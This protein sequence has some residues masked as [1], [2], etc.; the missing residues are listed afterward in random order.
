MKNKLFNYLTLF[1][2]SVVVLSAC[3]KDEPS[4]DLSGTV[5]NSTETAVSN[6]VIKLYS[7]D[8]EVSSTTS[9]SDGRYNFSGIK[10]GTYSIK[11]TKQGYVES[12]ED[13][14]IDGETSK[15]ITILGNA[16]VSGRIINSQTGEGLENATVSFA[17]N[18]NKS[19]DDMI[20]EIQVV[21]DAS[22][23]YSFENG[24]TGNFTCTI[25]ADGF[26]TRVIVNVII[27]AGNNS[28]E[29][30]TIVEVIEEGELRVVLTW[31]Q[32]PSDLDSH[33]TGPLASGE[34]FHI[35]YSH[36]NADNV[37]LDVDDT[38]SYGPETVTIN[39]FLNGMYRYS[40]FNYSEQSVEGGAQIQTSPTKVEV[41]DYTGKIH[42]FIAPAF[43]TGSGNTWR[44]FEINSTGSSINIVPINTYVQSSSSSTVEKSSGIKGYT[45]YNIYDF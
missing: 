5:I 2:L 13:V 42:T 30:S 24:P 3:K 4:Y 8:S 14:S 11:V 16:N 27:N 38:S 18:D 25:S 34:R 36:K 41:Y 31:G 20:I 15:N 23:Y 9:N 1:I 19:S 22:G 40:I 28:L 44:V 39:N 7:A 33:L 29:Q 12:S 45:S 21:T 26:T 32:N 35:Y 6:A 10:S 43:T 37:S 17:F